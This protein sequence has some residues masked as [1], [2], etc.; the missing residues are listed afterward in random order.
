MNDNEVFKALADPLRRRLLDRLYKRDGLSLAELCEEADMSRQAV[1]KHLDILERAN[2]ITTRMDGRSK[3]HYLN[4]VPIGEIADR[5][6]NKFRRQQVSE[7]IKLR[8]Q[9]EENNDD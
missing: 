6:L 1:S 2:L 3:R 4:P 5:W 8:K 9:L 7:L